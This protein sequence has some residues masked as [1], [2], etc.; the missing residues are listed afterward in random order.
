VLGVIID[1]RGRPL[2]L[3]KDP[4]ERREA[5]LKWLHDIGAVK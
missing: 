2:E 3:A 4:V 5:N 1:A